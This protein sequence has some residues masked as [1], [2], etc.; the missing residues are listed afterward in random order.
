MP[1]EST[2]EELYAI[3]DRYE[4]TQHL[5]ETIARILENKILTETP[6]PGDPVFDRSAWIRL[7]SNKDA[8]EAMSIFAEE[9][10]WR[11]FVDDSVD[12]L[13]VT[14]A[15]DKLLHRLE[16][17]MKNASGSPVC[18]ISGG[19]LRS[20]VTGSGIGGRN[21]SFALA[22]V[23]RIAGKRIA[24]LSAGTDGI[25]GNSRATGAVADGTSLFRAKF[26]GMD[27]SPYFA[28][29]DSNSFFVRLGDDIVTGP[30]GN[31][32]RDIRVLLGWPKVE[33]PGNLNQQ[34]G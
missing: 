33:F 6:K 24:L 32:V 1:D 9:A 2:L 25:D 5:P 30:T 31:N 18:V 14:E 27:P 10:G 17:E 13:P 7:M 19:E 21:Q 28:D 26:I 20:P 29:S 8:I 16:Q 4:L 12:D 34:N 15:A 3:V 23:D 11:H 22:C